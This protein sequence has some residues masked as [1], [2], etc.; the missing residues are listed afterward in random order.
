F[1]APRMDAAVRHELLERKTRHFAADGIEAGENHGLGRVVDDDVDAGRL[2]ER[3]D[4][5]TLAP[6]DAAL[7]LVRR[8]T[9]DGDGALRRVV[10]SNT[11]DGER[12]DV[13]RLAL[14]L[15]AG[16]LLDLADRVRGA[17]ARFLL[18]LLLELAAGLLGG[19]AGKG[20]EAV[21]RL[22][23]QPLR[24]RGLPFDLLPA[25]VQLVLALLDLALLLIQ[26]VVLAIERGAAFLDARFRPLHVLTPPPLLALPLFLRPECFFL[27]RQL[28]RLAEPL[29]ILLS[30]LKDARGLRLRVGLA[31]S[32]APVFHASA[33]EGTEREGR[34]GSDANQQQRVH[35]LSR[36]ALGTPGV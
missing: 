15:A 7:H 4:V 8:Q 5:A 10:G 20:L 16:V 19:H 31:P 28:G 3:P 2:L 29:G 36:R 32:Q 23:R 9:H 17:G 11:L 35:A 27:A 18:D 34:D 21:S 6:D 24:F 1:D 26:D 13:L 12:D 30:C 14:R 22:R 25:E 33:Q